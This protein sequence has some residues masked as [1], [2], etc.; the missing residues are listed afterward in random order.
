MKILLITAKTPEKL[1]KNFSHSA[2]VHMKTRRNRFKYFVHDCPRKL[3]FA[4]NSFMTP[5]NLVCLTILLAR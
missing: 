2:L 4:S 5:L 3:H 1:K